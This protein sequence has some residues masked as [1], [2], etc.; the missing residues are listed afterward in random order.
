MNSVDITDIDIP[1][2]SLVIFLITLNSAVVAS[3]IVIAVP[4]ALMF[5]LLGSL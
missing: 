3:V 4:L 1:F 5:S 2:G